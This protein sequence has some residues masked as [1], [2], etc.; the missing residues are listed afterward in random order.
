MKASDYI[1]DFLIQKGISDVF[2]YPGGMVVHLISSL[3][4]RSDEI[5]SHVT[6][7]EQGAAFAACGYA[8]T[9]L[10]PGVA[11]ATSGPGA[12]N[13]ITGI[14]NAFFD[15][16]P[17]IFITGQV[18]TYESKGDL[19][20][21]QKGFQETDIVSMVKDVTKYSVRIT[22]ADNLRFC[23]EKAYCLSM[24]GRPGPVLLDIPMNIQ[25]A[26]IEPESLKSYVETQIPSPESICKEIKQALDKSVRP[27]LVVGAGIRQAGCIEEFRKLTDI[28]EIP[29]I[30]SMIAIDVLPTDNKYNFGFLGAYGHR[31][32]NFVIAKSDLLITIGSRMDIRQT[33]ANR[34]VFAS[35]AKIVRI[36]IDENELTNKI[37]D[38]EVQIVGNL[39]EILP[40]L[41]RYFERTKLKSFV[42]W[43][44][45]CTEIKELFFD[46]DSSL[47]NDFIRKMSLMIP[48]NSV[49]TT[50]VG[51]NQVWVSQSF[52]VKKN[53]T[54]LYSG[55][56]GSMGYSLPASIGAFYASKGK[57]VFCINGDG[58]IQMNLQ[59]LQFIAREKLPIKIIIFNNKSLGMI[60]HFQDMYFHANYAQTVVGK[61]YEPSNFSKL[62]KAFDI[63]Y[64]CVDKY[65][66]LNKDLFDGDFPCVVEFVLNEK[67]YVYPK[68]AINKPIQDQEPPIDRELYNYIMDL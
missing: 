2:G 3:S 1:V 36:D 16:I 42:A 49:I 5:R 8:Q 18:N 34:E 30:T 7:N 41:K 27:C 44:N 12:T 52:K 40:R 10:K 64:H 9:S 51:Q 63:Q 24:E 11:Y 25:R 62:S 58:G 20:V 4:E 50:D 23:L 28:L 60:R 57:K 38:D 33:G 48:E 65:E 47:P 45:V 54:I 66:N 17:T 21:R 35:G 56:H 19:K 68:L 32:A 31:Y 61:G 22:D 43:L 15:S 29:V 37:K 13:L 67:T 14:C 55:G 46:K 6:Y 53:Q 59:E 26:E 39:K